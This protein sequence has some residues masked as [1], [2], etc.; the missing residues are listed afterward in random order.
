VFLFELMKGEDFIMR[1]SFIPSEIA[2]GKNL[3]TMLTA[4]FIRGV[5]GRESAMYAEV[6]RAF[7]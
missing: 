2:S 5:L 1:W 6:F 7:F 3:V 4:M